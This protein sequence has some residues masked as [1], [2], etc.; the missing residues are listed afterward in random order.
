M[1]YKTNLDLE[2]TD[3]TWLS[4][5]RIQIIFDW[6]CCCRFIFKIL[7]LLKL[8]LYPSPDL[9]PIWIRISFWGLRVEKLHIHNFVALLSDATFKV[10]YTDKRQRGINCKIVHLFAQSRC[11]VF[12][13][14]LKLKLVCPSFTIRTCF[15]LLFEH[16]KLLKL[17]RL[18]IH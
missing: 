4:K 13:W 7:Y 16:K 18:K 8:S 9:K 5:V 2:E 15:S 6:F 12:L 11:I 17:K 1:F 10:V 3:I 14:P